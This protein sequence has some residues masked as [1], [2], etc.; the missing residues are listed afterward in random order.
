MAAPSLLF[1]TLLLRETPALQHRIVTSTCCLLCQG[2]SRGVPAGI[3][4]T[5]STTKWPSRHRMKQL[6][7]MLQLRLLLKVVHLFTAFDADQVAY[8]KGS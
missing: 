7:F 8:A 2:H 3:L 4:P 5:N 1:I 6:L